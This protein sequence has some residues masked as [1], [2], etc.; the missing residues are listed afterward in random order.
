MIAL[1]QEYR[2]TS[3]YGPRRSPITGGNEFHTGIDLVKA[4]NSEIKAF[5]PGTVMHAKMGQTGTGV[6]GFGIT[7]I[8]Q[9]KYNH[10]QLYAHLSEACVTVGQKVAEGQVI[11]K[12]GSTGKST[13]QHLHFEVRENGKSFGYGNHIHPVKYVDDYYEKER[14]TVDNVKQC[15]DKDAAE[16]VIAVLGALWTASSDKQVQAAAHYAA[17]ALRDEVGIP[18][19]N[20]L[21]DQYPNH[22]N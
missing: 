21:T 3:P 16:K 1:M 8:I 6:G 12:Q 22:F 2:V 11:G 17:N 15:V 13:G 14:K 10:L 7:V 19:N 5:I 4:P 20:S 9:D 18:R